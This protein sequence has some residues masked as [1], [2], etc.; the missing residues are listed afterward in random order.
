MVKSTVHSTPIRDGD[1]NIDIEA[2]LLNN[3]AERFSANDLRL[4]RNAA[5]LSQLTG[6]KHT[7][8]T[9]QTCLE[10]GLQ[11]AELLAHLNMDAITLAAAI[12]YSSIQ[13]ADL[14]ET[15]VAEHLGANVASIVDGA[16]QMDCST[17]PT[18]WCQ[19]RQI[20]NR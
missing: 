10:Q 14:T 9:E 20:T 3:F 16:E 13:Y 2:W 11:M 19:A 7:T 12:V 18:Q 1:G 6:S 4:I 8:L 17:R 5:I 15:D